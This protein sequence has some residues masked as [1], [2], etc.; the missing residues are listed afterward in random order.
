MHSFQII[1]IIERLTTEL[2]VLP[3]DKMLKLLKLR[4]FWTRARAKY[5]NF[6]PIDFIIMF[7]SYFRRIQSDQT[8]RIELYFIRG[9]P[10][11]FKER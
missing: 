3:T 11:L 7:E 4:T 2:R 9:R 1:Y 6:S 10:K 8:E 5:L